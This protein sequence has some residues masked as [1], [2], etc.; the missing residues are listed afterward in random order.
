VHIPVIADTASNNLPDP[1]LSGQ[2]IFLS[3]ASVTVFIFFMSTAFRMGR[4]KSKIH[5]RMSDKAMIFPFSM[6]LLR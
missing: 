1:E 6:V 4:F 3:M 5:F 2:L